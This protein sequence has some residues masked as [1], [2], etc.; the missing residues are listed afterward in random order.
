MG[1]DVSVY[2]AVAIGESLVAEVAPRP[3]RIVVAVFLVGSNLVVSNDVVPGAIGKRYCLRA[4]GVGAVV[5]DPVRAELEPT[6]V[7]AWQASA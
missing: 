6:L 5:P 3:Q 7:A 1:D 4:S 2:V